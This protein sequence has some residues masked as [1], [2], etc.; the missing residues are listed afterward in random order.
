MLLDHDGYF[1]VYVHITDGKTHEINVA[2]KLLF[3][4]GSIVAYDREYVDYSFFQECTDNDV[5]FITRQKKN[6]KFTIV[7][8]HKIPK[9]RNILSDQII[10]VTGYYSSKKCTS[11]LR[12]VVVLDAKKKKK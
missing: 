9:Y 12:R 3:S 5:C 8:E 10:K 2:R 6:A 1:P 4:L 7:E 11:F